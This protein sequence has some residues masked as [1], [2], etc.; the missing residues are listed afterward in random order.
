MDNVERG[1]KI[2]LDLTEK[3]LEFSQKEAIET[4][5]RKYSNFV[6]FPI[7][8]N[9]KQVNTVKAL[10]LMAKNEINEKEHR[11]FYQLICNYFLL[12]S[13]FFFFFTH[14]PFFFFAA[15]S[16]DEP[17]YILHYS[18]DSPIDIRALLY[19]GQQ[20]GEK[21]GMGRVEPGLSL[22]C[23]KVL[24]QSKAKLVPE[25]L[26]FVKGVVDSE[27]IPLNISREH[28]Q[29]SS[30]VQRIGNVITKRIVKWLDEEARKDPKKYN[31]FFDEFGMFIKEGVCTDFPN[32]EDIAKLLRFE[33][34]AL[35]A[36]ESTSFDEYMQRA[37]A[38]QKDI[39]YLVAPTRAIAE[40]SP[41][42]EGFKSKNK[43]VHNFL[44][45]H[46]Y[47]YSFFLFK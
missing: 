46:L 33:S 17:Q 44:F 38:D 45:F 7:K 6:G 21:F 40:T 20:H 14:L 26:R 39:Y 35:P 5:I 2:V 3:D 15:H 30:L 12:F 47:L 43:E 11:E 16:Y 23:R 24:I 28:L 27:D 31:L 41:Y 25:W 18:T 34:S 8:V 19:I 10:W 36:G 4:I 9:G 37:P 13:F 29:D 1:T 32:K 22:Y 42:Y